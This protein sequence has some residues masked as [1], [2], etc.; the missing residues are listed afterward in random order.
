MAGG[1]CWDGKDGGGVSCEAGS[2]GVRG[3]GVEG[4]AP[5]GGADGEGHGLVLDRGRMWWELGVG[6]RLGG[7]VFEDLQCQAAWVGVSAFGGRIAGRLSGIGGST[8]LG[9][10]CDTALLRDDCR[11]SV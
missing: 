5:G 3:C 6:L 9:H 11:N 2:G 7:D 4:A 8:G 10:G 1:G